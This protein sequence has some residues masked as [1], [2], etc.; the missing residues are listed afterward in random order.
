MFTPGFDRAISCI[1]SLN[2]EGVICVLPQ[3][4]RMKSI[5]GNDDD[6]CPGA[7]P[8]CVQ[9]ILA[10]DLRNMKLITQTEHKTEVHVKDHPTVF[11]ANVCLM[12]GRVW[13]ETDIM[14]LFIN[15]VH[16]IIY[17]IIFTY[18]HHGGNG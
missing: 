17:K 15:P 5:S 11:L 14:N 18:C 1:R 9:I 13:L 10:P 2:P 8:G 12:Q 4:R 3:H 16:Q 7:F 6:S